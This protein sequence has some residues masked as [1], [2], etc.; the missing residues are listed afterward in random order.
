[1]LKS[2]LIQKENLQNKNTHNIVSSNFL[3]IRY[4]LPIYII[5]NNIHYSFCETNPL[6]NI[7]EFNEYVFSFL[8]TSLD[9]EL[10]LTSTKDF[11]SS[12]DRLFFGLTKEGKYFFRDENNNEIPIKEVYLKNDKG[13]DILN[14]YSMRHC[15]YKKND[16]TNKLYFISHGVYE[17]FTEIY[18]LNSNNVEL[19][20]INQTKNI[21]DGFLYHAEKSDFIVL[22]NSNQREF[23]YFFLAIKNYDWDNFY[24]SY[25]KYHFE[26][27]SIKFN[28]ENV[29]IGPIITKSTKVRTISSFIT[30]SQLIIVFYRN[31]NGYYSINVLDISLNVIN[32]LTSEY[33]SWEI[34]FYSQCIHL[35]EEIGIFILYSGSN[36]NYEEHLFL[37]KFDKQYYNATDIF[38]VKL[39]LPIQNG[40]S[41]NCLLKLKDNWFIYVTASKDYY[42]LYINIFS[43]YNNDQNLKMRNIKIEFHKYFNFRFYK[44]ISLANYDNYLALSTSGCYPEGEEECNK[45]KA[46]TYLIIFSYINNTGIDINLV[47]YYSEQNNYT[48]NVSNLI[49]IEN[50]VFGDELNQQ[51]TLTSIPNEIQ[52]YKISNTNTETK[53]NINDK[54]DIT[55]DKFKINEK[56]NVI[57]TSG[58][59][60]IEYECTLSHASYDN[61]D[62]IAY[63]KEIYGE[64]TS[65]NDKTLYENYFG[66][67]YTRKGRLKFK[68]CHEF[69]KTCYFLGFSNEDQKCISCINGYTLN[70]TNKTNNCIPGEESTNNTDT[71]CSLNNP[72]FLNST[73]ECSSKCTIDD[74]LNSDCILYY[75]SQETFSN[76]YEL[77]LSIMKNNNELNLVLPTTDNLIFQL[78]NTSNEIIESYNKEN[79][80]S[81]VILGECET[82]LKEEYN[83]N[84]NLSLLILKIE[85]TDNKTNAKNVQYEIFHPI[86]KTKLDL[87]ICSNTSIYILIPKRIDNKTQ[88]L[89]EDLKNKGYDLFNPNDSFY[90]DVCSK[91]TT[92]HGT[93][94]TLSDRKKDYYINDTEVYCQ[95]GCFYKNYDIDTQNYICECNANTENINLNKEYHFN[96]LII[97]SSFY[98]VIKYSNIA[99]MK[100]YKLV[101][102]L[103]GQKGNVGSFIV[104]FLG[105]AYFVFLCIFLIFGFKKIRQEMIEII[106][107]TFEQ[108]KRK[109][110]KKSKTENNINKNNFDIN[111]INS[112]KKNILRERGSK[113]NPPDKKK[114]KKKKKKIKKI[115]EAEDSN[116]NISK[117]GS[118]KKKFSYR[119]IESQNTKI[120]YSKDLM[121]SAMSNLN[122]INNV[123]NEINIGKR[124]IMKSKTISKFKKISFSEYELNELNYLDALK[125]DKRS[126]Y[127]YYWSLCKKEHLILFTFIT[128]D[129]Y[130]IT[131]IK[132][133]LF[134]NALALDFTINC[135]F[136]NDD[137]MHKIYIDYGAYNFISE[138]P[139]MVY[140]TIISEIFDIVI[141]SLCLSEGDIYD[142]KK[143][144][145]KIEATD[146]FQ[147]ILKKIKIKLAIFF[148]L[149][150]LIM[151]YC[152]YFISAF[153][154]VYTNTQFIFIKD[155]LGSF[156]M[157]LIYPFGLYMIPAVL[158]IIILRDNKKNKECLFKL[159]NILPIV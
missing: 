146:L 51:V 91:Y 145:N 45:Y 125:Y 84:S 7:L 83:I 61:F 152:W 9:G 10:F 153:C 113:S 131:T 89:F 155:S 148:T 17:Y 92:E 56:N 109:M 8:S 28:K 126:F 108:V 13:E 30:E 112:S 70:K 32:T 132:L 96:G 107:F 38:H 43:L 103:E 72:Y 78:T 119:L 42:D 48:I 143:A 22:P 80:L 106:Y 5:I 41:L 158:R 62:S 64:D 4:L 36:S 19:K 137:S 76:A 95:D 27:D 138:I 26:G 65:Q 144:K 6:N 105:V 150:I 120:Q 15:F 99:V 21:N 25:L 35:K 97:I 2:F 31:N 116:E 14:F 134:V 46:L 73:N 88:A 129:D 66:S 94:V 90:N 111:N 39:E 81:S 55:N 124:K 37:K 57:K 86:N 142:L 47:N 115:N 85:K 149:T 121:K 154:A 135:F 87:S 140:S 50:N 141:K 71:K 100:C 18:E 40:F 156:I 104:I 11:D 147:K 159:S 117:I 75:S 58:F 23:L 29:E 53:L 79:E 16:S 123:Q 128:C 139:Q 102:S 63:N 54:I 60:Y 130:N 82:L 133:I 74:M 118:N 136:F 151:F 49:K 114:K 110:Y 69:C 101:F 24:I 52:L 44:V 12:P 77:M 122:N 157:S 33:Q 68:L 127:Q 98:D 67:T 20:F 34:D 93:D 3:I 59:Y 1:M